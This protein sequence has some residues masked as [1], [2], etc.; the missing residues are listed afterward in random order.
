MK[1]IKKSL[2]LQMKV[3]EAEIEQRKRLFELNDETISIIKKYSCVI[4]NK[5]DSIIHSF[6]EKQIQNNEI[7]L[8]IGDSDTLERLKKAQKQYVT[9]LFQGV[10]DQNYVNYRLRVGLTHKRIGV[11][12]KLYLSSVMILKETIIQELQKFNTNMNEEIELRKSL[13]KV[14]QFDVSYIFDTYIRFLLNEVD[15]SKEILEKYAE[16]LEDKIYEKTET[17]R[18]ISYKDQLSGLYNRRGFNDFGLKKLE[19]C[20]RK[21]LPLSMI[22]LDLNN[23]KIVNDSKGHN[24]GDVLIQKFSLAISQSLRGEDSGFRVGGDEFCILLPGC[25]KENT[26][27]VIYKIVKSAWS[28]DRSIIFAFGVATTGPKTYMTLDE[29]ISEADGQMYLHKKLIKSCKIF[30]E[31]WEDKKEF[32]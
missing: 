31:H 22:Y 2:S 17:L 26:K 4:N 11:P 8:L 19:F 1:H 6:Y 20:K 29:L 12:P 15:T 14:L 30:K 7:S 13:D 28:I 16:E 10:Y 3:T 5:I 18:E 27:H 25:S 9:S 24:E 32:K 21:Q 23:L